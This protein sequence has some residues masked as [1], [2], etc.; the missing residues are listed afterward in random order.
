[1]NVIGSVGY[2]FRDILSVVAD[3]YEMGIGK[4]IRSPIDDLVDY[5]VRSSK[6]TKL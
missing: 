5:H 1:L 3:K 4:I 6:A 2:S